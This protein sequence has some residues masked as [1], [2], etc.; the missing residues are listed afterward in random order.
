MKRETERTYVYNLQK[1]I[2]LLINFLFTDQKKNCRRILPRLWSTAFLKSAWNLS[3]SSTSTCNCL[4]VFV[5]LSTE[6][7]P[8]VFRIK[9][10]CDVSQFNIPEMAKK[11]DV[12]LVERTVKINRPNISQ[13]ES[14]RL[15]EQKSA[16]KWLKSKTIQ[17]KVQGLQLSA[18]RGP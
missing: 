1:N 17:V 10:L 2:L 5:P 14:L 13:K 16:Q 4:N 6:I 7:E 11:N 9:I 8:A 12:H 3:S 15:I 18:Q